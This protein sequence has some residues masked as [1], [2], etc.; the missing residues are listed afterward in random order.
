ML[1]SEIR[2]S[3]QAHDHRRMYFCGFIT[4]NI[5]GIDKQSGEL[6]DYYFHST[7]A[8]VCIQGLTTG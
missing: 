1:Y 8:S 3:A 2:L 6:I 7:I 4:R 5:V